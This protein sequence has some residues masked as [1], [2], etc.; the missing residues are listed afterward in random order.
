MLFSLMGLILSMIYFNEWSYYFCGYMLIGVL[1]CIK[2]YNEGWFYFSISL[3]TAMDLL[4]WNLIYLTFW[5]SSLMMMASVM[6]FVKRNFA[7]EFCVVVGLLTLSLVMVFLVSD[8]LWFY[9]FFEGSLIPTLFLI[10]GWG[11]QPE[12]LKAGIYLFF[13]T[14]CGSLPLLLGILFLS[15]EFLGTNFH[16]FFM[17]EISSL[18]LY[19]SFTL[20]FLVSMP[21]FLTHLWLPSAHVEAPIS[22][23]MVLAGVLLKLGGYG[24][25][26][27]AYLFSL[28][29]LVVGKIL[30]VLSLWGGFIL[31]LL[32]LRQFDLKS[33]I[34]YSSVVHMGMVIGGLM[35]M[36]YWG[37]QG[38][39][40]LMIGHG[41]CSSGMFAAANILYERGGT[42]SMVLNSGMISIF[43]SF[44][45]WWFLLCVSNMAAPPSLN[46]LGEIS[47]MISLMIWSKSIFLL[48]SLLS[49]F[50]AAYSLYIFSLVSH[51]SPSLHFSFFDIKSREL[52]LLIFHW[53]P[54]NVLVLKGDL[55][56]AWV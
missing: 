56:M 42:R 29:I 21:M 48:L 24:I 44:I 39:L 20:A 19:F 9:I 51:G 10:S 11:Y 34:A 40:I 54:L 13:Y 2:G 8:F 27:G 46:L 4:S 35:M 25:L 15:S 36:N 7:T 5:V 3:G 55:L 50:S 22:G 53:V 49:F 14:M 37:F 18:V 23:S 12:R 45:L 43:P 17:E 32:C 33:L 16:I 38:V 31:S 52:M 1:V 30:V 6:V 47:L 41:L 28:E 26:R